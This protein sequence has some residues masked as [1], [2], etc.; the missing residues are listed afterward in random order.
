M[1]VS[2]WD[3][4]ALW[5][6]VTTIGRIMCIYTVSRQDCGRGAQEEAWT[7]HERR[8][9]AQGSFTCEWNGAVMQRTIHGLAN[10][11]SSSVPSVPTWCTRGVLHLLLIRG[12]YCATWV[13]Q[14]LLQKNTINHIII[15][16]SVNAQWVIILNM[17]P[18]MAVL[19]ST[20]KY[21]WSACIVRV[22]HTR[23]GIPEYIFKKYLK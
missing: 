17:V 20:L 4:T 3:Q 14:C 5:I 1:A 8:E 18:D 9:Q 12:I 23:R 6:T 21:S 16:T 2:E 22:M 19:F 13:F 10:S 7:L 15:I 11:P